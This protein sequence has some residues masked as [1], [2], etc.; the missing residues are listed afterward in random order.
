MSNVWLPYT[1]MKT[2]LEP[3][4]VRSTQGCTITLED[5]RQLIDGVSS[6]WS[7]C[8][9]YNHPHILNAMHQQLKHMP[10]VM[11]GGLTHSPVERLAQSLCQRL[12]NASHVFFSESGSVAVEVALKMVVQYWLNQDQSQRKQF[13]HF[14]HGYHGDTF[15]AMSVC[16]PTEGM[17]KLFG[18][19]L[20]RH[21]LQTIPKT[22][23]QFSQFEAFLERNHQSLA[24]MIIEPL[25]Q[26]AGGMKMHKPQDLNR[27]VNMV[28]AYELPVIFDEIFTGFGRTGT[29]F[30]LDK[31]DAK[32]DIVCLGK[33]LTGGV[34]PLAATVA[35]KKIFEAFLSDDPSAALMHGP[36]FT[37]HA[38]GCSAALASLELF[39]TKP[40]LEQ[41]ASIESFFVETFK[42]FESEHVKQ[43]R[44]CGAILVLEFHKAF[45]PKQ[46]QTL[47]QAFMEQGVWIRPFGN[48]IYL[49]PAFTIDFT[50]LEVLCDSIKRVAQLMRINPIE[51]SF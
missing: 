23:E 31:L 21:A 32:P 43:I 26:G 24:G 30:A 13:I 46:L 47:K 16:C 4:R 51:F 19:T 44:T 40:R 33:A 17:H 6:W 34:T 14:Q 41:V 3:P 37:G 11:L 10:H 2:V 9:G 15:Y 7:A 42:G 49:A 1:Q 28:Q 20:P 25:V 38:L 50:E 18:D 36:T 8:H 5:G 27:L 35:N 45:E 22:S 29:L 12:P 48:I 39:D